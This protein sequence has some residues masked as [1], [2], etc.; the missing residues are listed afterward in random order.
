MTRGALAAMVVACALACASHASADAGGDFGLG[1]I[2]GDPTGVSGKH[3][4]SD[5]FAVDWALGLAFIAGH[6]IRAHADFLWQLDIKRW[7]SATLG[8]HVG[9]GPKIGLRTKKN[10]DDDFLFGARGPF[11]LS[12]RFLKVPLDVFVEVAAGLWIVQKVDL[13]ID[14]A[15]GGRYWF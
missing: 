4:L 8:L 12:L 5:E 6:D 9:V 3:I 10:N 11:G 1:L 7:E 14:G 15:I 13:H 2:I